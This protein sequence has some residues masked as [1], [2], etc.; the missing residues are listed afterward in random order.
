MK[1]IL[2]KCLNLHDSLGWRDRKMHTSVNK[3]YT[4]LYTEEAGNAKCTCAFTWS[5]VVCDSVWLQVCLESFQDENKT[6]VKR[7]WSQYMCTTHQHQVWILLLGDHNPKN[8]TF[9]PFCFRTRT[10]SAWR[11]VGRSVCTCTTCSV[12]S[13]CTR[14]QME[15][16]G[17]YRTVRDQEY[18]SIYQRGFLIR[19]DHR[20]IGDMHYRH[21]SNSHTHLQIDAPLPANSTLKGTSCRWNKMCSRFEDSNRLI[22]GNTT[23]DHDKKTQSQIWFLLNR[24]HWYGKTF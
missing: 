11:S 13:L 14:R 7:Q 22:G 5:H 8:H 6:H 10:R 16:K 20:L 18:S 17:K 15:K 3:P 19:W 24:K 2:W 12:I 21:G 4:L 9:L 1:S 23:R